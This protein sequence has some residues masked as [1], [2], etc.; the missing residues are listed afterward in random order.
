M[1]ERNELEVVQE[2]LETKQYTKLR[3]LLAEM[4][5]ADIA[6]CMDE[7]DEPEM[8]KVFRILPKDL[9]ADVFSYL[10]VENQQMIITS[11]TDKEAAHIIDTLM[12]DDAVDLLE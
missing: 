10:E 4:N 9:A 2:L 12:A 3:Q 5:D 11:M 7:L 8:L 1:E 6:A